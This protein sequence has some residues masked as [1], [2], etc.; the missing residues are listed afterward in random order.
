[1]PFVIVWLLVVVFGTF[2]W[3]S[4][5][6]KLTQADFEAP[7]AEEVLRSVGVVVA[8]LGAVMGYVSVDQHY[9]DMEDAPKPE[10]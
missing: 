10:R 9:V 4:N 6:V 2:G 5:I 1:M 7:Y 8:P 3:I